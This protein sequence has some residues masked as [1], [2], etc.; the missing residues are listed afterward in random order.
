VTLVLDNAEFALKTGDAA[1]IS[2]NAPYRWVNS[3]EEPAQ[4]LVVSSRAF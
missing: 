1:T 3:S 2:A 4:L